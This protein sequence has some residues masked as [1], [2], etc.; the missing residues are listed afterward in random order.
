MIK[1]TS[2]TLLFCTALL[3]SQPTQGSIKDCEIMKQNVINI[4]LLLQ[5]SDDASDDQLSTL[6]FVLK[7]ELVYTKDHCYLSSKELKMYNSQ[8]KDLEDF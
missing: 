5:E 6:F 4:N 8:I 3:G 1:L 2:L 7:R